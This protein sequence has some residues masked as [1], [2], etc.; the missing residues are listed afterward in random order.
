MA[1]NDPIAPN[2]KQPPELDDI[3]NKLKEKFAN[4]NRG[5]KKTNGGQNK[6]G[7]PLLKVIAIIALLVWL[8]SGFYIIDAGWKGVVF[9]FGQFQEVTNAGPHWHL[10]YPIESRMAVYA[11]KIR[12][13]SIGFRQINS[14][15]RQFIGNVS[16][17]SLMLTKDENIIDAKF[18]VQYQIKSVTDYLFK[19][20]NPEQTLKQ[21]L[22]SS[23]RLIAGRNNMD[24]IITEGRSDVVAQIEQNAQ[25]LLDGYQTGLLITA[26]NMKD[27]Q[28]P[29][30]VQAAFSDVVKAREDKERLIN[31]A[32]TY[33]NGILPQ[34]R[35]EAA[36]MLEEARAYQAQIVAKAEGETDRF[37]KIL[38]EYEKAPIVT[39]QRLYLE[40]MEA[41]LARTSKVVVDNQSNNLMYLPL[42]KLGANRAKT[43]TNVGDQSQSGQSQLGNQQ[44]QKLGNIRNIFRSREVR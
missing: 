2:P 33:A 30:P 26:V 25:T 21:A 40:T 3:I 31:E 17:E 39:K 22:Q 4:F 35:G 38:T 23:I 24:Y 8:G 32:Q 6:L 9:R 13:V 27:A 7:A 19:V 34:A 18:E 16:T 10:P 5:G 28:A 14:Q 29:E 12:S 1:W 36:R 15:N 43:L 37:K 42:D 20:A 44:R 11:D 41:V